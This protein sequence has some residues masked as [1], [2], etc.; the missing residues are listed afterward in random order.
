MKEYHRTMLPTS[1]VIKIPTNI[2]M[3]NLQFEIQKVV[4]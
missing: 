4:T 2:S 1:V 3:E